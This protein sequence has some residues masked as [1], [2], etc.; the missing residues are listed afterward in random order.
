[1]SSYIRWKGNAPHSDRTIHQRMNAVLNSKLAIAALL[2]QE[3]PLKWVFTGDSITHGSYHTM[4]SRDYT[5]HFSERL[6]SELGRVRDC[7]IKTGVSGW[8]IAH[9]ADDLEWNV[10]QYAPHVVSLNFG[11]NDCTEGPAGL[12]RFINVYHEVIKRIQAA[13]GAAIILHTPNLV[14]KAEGSVC[15]GPLPGYVDAVREIASAHGALLVD[16]ALDWREAEALG[17]LTYRLSDD[18]HPNEYGHRAMA[19]V[20]FKVLDRWDAASATCRLFVP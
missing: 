10:L 13:T 14:L 11:M 16:H 18:I 1:M 12:P 17:A 6:R 5:E 8:R 2:A 4:G 19:H 7:V 20:L 9:I 15:H 3:A